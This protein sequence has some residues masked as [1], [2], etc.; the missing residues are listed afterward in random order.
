MVDGEPLVKG[1]SRQ[2]PPAATPQH[3]GC[4]NLGWLGG[5]N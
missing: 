5:K 1:Q 3:W 2:T 4:C